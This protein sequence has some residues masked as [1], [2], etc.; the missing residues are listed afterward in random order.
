MA[1]EPQI[2]QNYSVPISSPVATGLTN[3]SN[4][5]VQAIGANPVRRKIDFINPNALRTVYVCPGNLTAI[6][7]GGSI[8]I[9]PGGVLSISG[10]NVN[11]AWNAIADQAGAFGL[12]ILEY[13]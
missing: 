2:Q 4:V 6:A 5:S 12:T 9:F 3:L 8:P 11:C 10:D 1:V 13:L 7:G